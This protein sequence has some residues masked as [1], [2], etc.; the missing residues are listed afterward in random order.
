MQM[1]GNERFQLRTANIDN[2][3]RLE[4]STIGFWERLGRAFFDVRVF[5]RFAPT[6]LKHQLKGC[7]YI[8][9]SMANASTKLSMGALHP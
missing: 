6:N 4:I 1:L 5:N 2:N 8:R 9:D 3:A 7:V